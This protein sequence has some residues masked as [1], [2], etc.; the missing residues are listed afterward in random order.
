MHGTMSD[1]ISNVHD[2][3]TALSIIKVYEIM[4][5]TCRQYQCNRYEFYGSILFLVY[6]I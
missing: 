1:G 2:D 4:S 3:C 6:Q 5:G